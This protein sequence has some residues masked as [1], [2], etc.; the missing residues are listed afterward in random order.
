M[1]SSNAHNTDAYFA[2]ARHVAWWIEHADLGR[3]TAGRWDGARVPVTI[4]HIFLPASASFTLLNGGF[5]LR[6]PSGQFYAM[7]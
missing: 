6:G 4:D 7:T 1:P 2:D 5:F 3:L